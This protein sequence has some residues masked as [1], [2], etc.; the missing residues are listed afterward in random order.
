ML[1]QGDF[2]VED[3]E[4]EIPNAE[5]TLRA[6]NAGRRV[7]DVTKA[8]NLKQSFTHLVRDGYCWGT[9]IFPRTSR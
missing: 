8:G 6:Y 9:N 4:D 3:Q 1:G 7:L 2:T 5:Q